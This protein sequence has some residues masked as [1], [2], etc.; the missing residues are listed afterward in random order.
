MTLTIRVIFFVYCQTKNKI[1]TAVFQSFFFHFGLS[2]M[3]VDLIIVIA[4]EE[5]VGVFTSLIKMS[6]RSVDVVVEEDDAKHNNKVVNHRSGT[7][8]HLEVSKINQV[9]KVNEGAISESA[10]SLCASLRSANDAS[11]RELGSD[12]ELIPPAKSI[13][14]IYEDEFKR[15]RKEYR[16]FVIQRFKQGIEKR[17]PNIIV[18]EKME[19]SWQKQELEAVFLK[20]E[21]GYE[22]TYDR[23]NTAYGDSKVTVTVSIPGAADM[24]SKYDK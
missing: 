9:N 13:A 10:T 20:H 22:L 6:S 5:L 3:D 12:N 17:L 21:Q 24:I 8:T 4:L 15:K 7:P 23:N 14:R 1:F 2:Q 16:H 18:D 19:F 11:K